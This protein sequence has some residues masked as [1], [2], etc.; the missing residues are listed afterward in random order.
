M[1]FRLTLALALIAITL[2]M[3]SCAP[4]QNQVNSETTITAP[5]GTKT[6]TKVT[7][8][9]SDAALAAGTTLMQAGIALAGRR[10]IAEK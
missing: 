5:D 1:K 6:V 7:A 9:N 2:L 8:T 4:L 3:E 10:I